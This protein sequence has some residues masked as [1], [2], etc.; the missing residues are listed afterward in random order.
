MITSDYLPM[1]ALDDEG[2]GDSKRTN[3][4]RVKGTSKKFHELHHLLAADWPD[5]E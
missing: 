5:G 1:I 4:A 2:F 3:S